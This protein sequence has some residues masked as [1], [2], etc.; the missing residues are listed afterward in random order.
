MKFADHFVN[1]AIPIGQFGVIMLIWID[2]DRQ[3]W[4]APL[5]TQYPIPGLPLP[6]LWQ[7]VE[8]E[9]LW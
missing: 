2:Q 6:A 7:K 3:V 1:P 9:A 8:D 5:G 4:R